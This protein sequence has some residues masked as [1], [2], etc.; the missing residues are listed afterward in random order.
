MEL[1]PRWANCSKVFRQL[2]S[3]ERA[4]IRTLSKGNDDSVPVDTLVVL[5]RHEL[6]AWDGKSYA[7]T[8]DGRAMA[9]F[10]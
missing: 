4:A 2:S 10:C 3:A 7:L 8:A 6:I 9:F 1:P 5:R